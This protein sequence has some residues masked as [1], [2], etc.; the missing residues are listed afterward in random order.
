MTGDNQVTRIG[1]A[2]GPGPGAVADLDRATAATAAGL[3]RPSCASAR[4]I[5]R[6]VTGRP[7]RPCRPSWPRPTQ[8]SAALGWTDIEQALAAHPRIGD[9]APSGPVGGG[10]PQPGDAAQPTGPWDAAA[11][12]PTATPRPPGRRPAGDRDR[13]AA[14]GRRP[15]RGRSS[16]GPGTPRRTC[17]PGC[18]RRRPRNGSGTCS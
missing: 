10:G 18:G 15:G 9:R 16:P 8:R 7:A 17:S 2:P 12:R 13:R 11:R 5:E 1:A 4:W 3:L 14:T 6:L